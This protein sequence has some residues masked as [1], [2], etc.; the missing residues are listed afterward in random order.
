ME[1]KSFEKMPCSVARALEHV[2]EWW[3]ILILRDAMMGLKRFD[4]FQTSLGIA[5]N[6]LTR[7][8]N[9]LVESGLLEKRLYSERPPR[10]EYILTESGRDFLPVMVA[11][12]TWGNKHYSPRGMDTLVVSNKNKEVVEPIMIDKKTGEELSFAHVMFA[13]GPESPRIK[14]RHF[15]NIGL[16]VIEN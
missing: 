11:I 10:H 15:E 9:S 12:A 16:P 1:K 4:E 13:A 8:L 14:K 3:N 5:P 6:T 2:G 7:R